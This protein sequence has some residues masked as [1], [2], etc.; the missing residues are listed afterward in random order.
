MIE[1]EVLEKIRPTPEERKKIR[2]IIEKCTDILRERIIEK[3][4]EAEVCLTGSMAKDT[5]ISGDKNIDL[6]LIFPHK[7]PEEDMKRYGLELG[8]L[9][10]HDIAYAEHPYVR[11]FYEDYEV[12]VVPAYEFKEEIRSS[13]DRTPLHTE[14]VLEFLPDRDE[15]RLLKKF[16]RSIGVYGSDLKMEGLSGYLCELLVIRYGS[17]CNVLEAASYWKPGEL[18]YLEERPEKEFTEPLVCIDPVDPDRNVAAVLSLENFA[19]FIHYAREYL[20]RPDISS[21]FREPQR[22]NRGKGTELYR[23]D[24]TVDLIDDILFPQL[25][26]TQEFLVKTL[27]RH[28]FQVF[29][30]AVFDSGILVELS[31]FELPPLRKHIGP[32]IGEREHCLTFS[33]RHRVVGFQ[34]DKIY[35][36]VKRKHMRAQDLLKALVASRQ[37]FGKDL[38][39]AK[40]TLA[41]IPG[42]VN[43]VIY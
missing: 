11:N 13:V 41:L 22:Y 23:I 10:D 25:R 26:K 42:E 21:F 37:G 18:I 38:T 17:F 34:G 33:Q 36:V 5:W 6:F 3:G 15:V 4:I 24:F 31:V 32:P 27:E 29:N 8:T 16:A 39:K 30:S 19:K 43:V 28:D 2:E 20:N 9:F 12:D 14:Y 1:E 7:Y 40:A 35:A